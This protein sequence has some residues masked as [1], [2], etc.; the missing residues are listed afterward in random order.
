M[1]TN[2][3]LGERVF[4]TVKQVTAAHSM[5]CN[6]DAAG[7]MFGLVYPDAGNVC[8]IGLNNGKYETEAERDS[9]ICDTLEEAEKW[10]Y[11]NFVKDEY[12]TLESRL[13]AVSKDI[14]DDVNHG[15]IH[16]IKVGRIIEL[17]AILKDV[18]A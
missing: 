14:I 13:L 10:L 17:R 1:L 4:K 15:T 8:I 7:W 18:A 3:G 11:L 2:N 16:S 6:D 12:P 9:I 5:G